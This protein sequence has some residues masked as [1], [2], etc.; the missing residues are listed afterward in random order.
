MF[1]VKRL[2]ARRNLSNVVSLAQRV[3]ASK[4]PTD[5]GNTKAREGAGTVTI[6]YAPDIDG[7]ADPGEIVWAWVP[8]EEDPSRGKDRPLVV[9]GRRDG[10]RVGVP[11]TSKRKDRDDRVPVGTGSWD[12][13]GRPSYAVVDRLLDLDGIRREGAVLDRDRF[14]AVVSAVDHYH[15]VEIET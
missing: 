7:D 1:D 14:D 9:I 4:E 10:R 11:L 6:E 5:P 15:D 3:L 13:K 12:R 2:L 8:Y